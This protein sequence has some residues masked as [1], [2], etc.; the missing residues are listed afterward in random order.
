MF[1][2]LKVGAKRCYDEQ[3]KTCILSQL[4][5]GPDTSTS[6]T[7]HYSTED[8][9]EILRHATQRHIQVIPEFDFPGHSHA[10][11]KSMIARHDRLVQEGKEKEAKMFLLNDFQD[12]SRYLSVQAFTD[13]TATCCLNSTFDLME[14]ILRVLVSLHRD[15]QPLTVYHF[16]G[17]E[18]PGGAW[19]KSPACE[20]L[21]KILN[22]PY[23]SIQTH[24][25]LKE[26]FLQR[27]SNITA[28]MNVNIGGWGDFLFERKTETVLSREFFSNRDVYSFAW[29]VTGAAKHHHEVSLMANHGYKVT[30]LYYFTSYFVARFNDI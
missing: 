27:L 3:E 13:E 26:Y 12:E 19:Q 23:R 28:K 10:A 1:Y 8:Y 6:G 4:G 21:A 11:I 24:K 16:G 14:S 5:S 30:V 15:I 9:R 25:L 22:I 2:L 7:G 17:D 18:V 20:K 29:S